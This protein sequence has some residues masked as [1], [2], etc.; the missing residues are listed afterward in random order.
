MHDVLFRH[1]NALREA[2]LTR[3]AAELGLD[4]DRF[5]DDLHDRR[6]ALRVQRDIDSA[7]DSG[8]A[9]TPTSMQSLRRAGLAS[10]TTSAP[11]ARIVCSSSA[12][13]S[14][15]YPSAGKTGP[16]CGKLR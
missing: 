7:D 1:Q 6:H 10:T 2:D 4:T 13:C 3:Y 8:A 12:R 15:E 9:G 16:M 5:L 14:G 11:L